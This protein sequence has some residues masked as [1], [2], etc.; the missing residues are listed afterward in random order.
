MALIAP[1]NYWLSDD[2][3]KLMIIH[4]QVVLMQKNQV[5][6]G[7]SKTILNIPSP[8]SGSYQVVIPMA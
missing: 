6:R 7:S 2:Q 3:L 5:V 8:K 1:L 4:R